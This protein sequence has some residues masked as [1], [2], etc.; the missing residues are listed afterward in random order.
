LVTQNPPSFSQ[1]GKM[2]TGRRPFTRTKPKEI[3]LFRNRVKNS[4]NRKNTKITYENF[5]LIF[6]SP[7]DQYAK[8]IL[9][10]R[11]L[12]PA[13]KKTVKILQLDLQNGPRKKLFL[14]LYIQGLW[15]D[16]VPST[17]LVTW[18]PAEKCDQYVSASSTTASKPLGCSVKSLGRS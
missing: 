1:K 5:F 17:Q 15:P 16:G 9:R 6:S 7:V 8:M 10:V 13:V 2:W 12:K 3:Q 4:K 18:H 11:L 14:V